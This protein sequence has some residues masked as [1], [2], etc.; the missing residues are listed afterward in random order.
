MCASASA[1]SAAST[2]TCGARGSR[3]HALLR[4]TFHWAHDKPPIV[5]A[6]AADAAARLIADSGDLLSGCNAPLLCLLCA[7][8]DE[9]QQVALLASSHL[10]R[11]AA[12]PARG[13]QLRRISVSCAAEALTAAAASASAPP[14]TVLLALRTVHGA[15]KARTG[16]DRTDCSASMSG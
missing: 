10:L 4:R 7:A 14:A 3:V 8:D 16:V 13:G 11:L 2:L 5:R 9:W 1:S 15:V 12:E 6:A